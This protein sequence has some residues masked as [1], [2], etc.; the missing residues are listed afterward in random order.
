MSAIGATAADALSP[1]DQRA[2]GFGDI[3]SQEFTEIILSELSNQDPL[4]PN[5]T[6]ALLEQLS[7]IRSIESDAQ[8]TEQL[9]AMVA[10]SELASAASLIGALVSGVSAGNQRVSDVVVSVTRT[11]QG[12][13]LNMSG[14]SRIPM[15]QVDEIL[16]PPRS[17]DPGGSGDDADQ[18]D[19]EDQP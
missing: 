2:S 13:I 17:L 6:S 5:D 4:E 10:Q 7:T 18:G 8:L 19:E 9:G 14:G 12:A 15:D 3:S 11:D 1:R 16:V